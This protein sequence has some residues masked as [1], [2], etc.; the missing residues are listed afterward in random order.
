MII[1]FTRTFI[2]N[3]EDLRICSATLKKNQGSI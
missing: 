3:T 2:I 1:L